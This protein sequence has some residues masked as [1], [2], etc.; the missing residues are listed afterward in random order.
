M[1]KLKNK[2]QTSDKLNRR[3]NPIF[4]KQIGSCVKSLESQDFKCPICLDILVYPIVNECGHRVCQQCA[5][6]AYKVS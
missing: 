6:N 5:E 4:K 1:N 2:G 3:N